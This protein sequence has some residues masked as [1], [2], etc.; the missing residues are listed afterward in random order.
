MFKTETHLHTAETSPCG[1]V[2]AG[3]M[4]KKYY[5]AGYQTVF[6]TDH[7]YDSF[8]KKLG[9]LTWDEKVEKYL[10][11]YR[12]AKAAGDALGMNV[13]MSAELRLT[14]SVNDYL[15]YGVDEA[16]FRDF[17]NAFDMSIEE[18]Y[19]YAKKCGITVIQAHPLR[20]NKC[21]P[22]PE[23]ADGL[24]VH[25]GNPRHENFTD[26]VV[27]L[28][29]EYH[30]LMTA[31]S[32]AHRPEDVGTSGIMTEKEIRTA[33][34]YVDALKSGDYIIIKGDVEE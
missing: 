24:E 20:N 22:T 5:E 14:C 1:K 17:N 30:K 29:K 32:D 27:S 25:N 28:A 31:G 2:S 16:V 10:L 21:T 15:L 8:F 12:V 26:K 9:E 23:F 34:D 11:G 19:C 7:F 13:L 18:F 4:M 33:D 3:E 6:I